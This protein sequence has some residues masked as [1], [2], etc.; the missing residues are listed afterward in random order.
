MVDPADLVTGPPYHLALLDDAHAA[1]ISRSGGL[2]LLGVLR[3][4]AGPTG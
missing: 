2:L 1:A 4:R 3:R